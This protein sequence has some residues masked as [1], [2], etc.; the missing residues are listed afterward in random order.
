ME[1]KDAEVVALESDDEDGGGVGKLVEGIDEDEEESEIDL[2]RASSVEG[3]DEDE[4]EEEG[5]FIW[6]VHTALLDVKKA[7]VF[8]LGEVSGY[9]P[10][11]QSI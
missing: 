8:C 7:A 10:D 1:E 4:D 3:G 11:M 6:D 2:S 5:Q 9:L